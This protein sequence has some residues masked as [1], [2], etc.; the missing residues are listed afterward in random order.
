MTPYPNLPIVNQEPNQRMN[1]STFFRLANQPPPHL[2]FTAHRFTALT[3]PTL[4]PIVGKVQSLRF[5]R[6]LLAPAIDLYLLDSAEAAAVTTGLL[7]WQ[8]RRLRFLPARFHT[9]PARSLDTAVATY[10]A[11]QIP[12]LKRLIQGLDSPE[13]QLIL[14]DLLREGQKTQTAE[15]VFYLFGYQPPNLLFSI[16]HV[17]DTTTSLGRRAKLSPPN[18]E[19]VDP[20]TV[21]TAVVADPVAGGVN[22]FTSLAFLRQTF[23]QLSRVIIIAPHLT[24]YGALALS[25]FLDGEGLAATF[26]GFGAL[27][28]SNPPDMYFSPTPVNDPER[29]VDLRHKELMQLLYG[30]AAARLCVAGNWTAMFLAPRVG[31]EWFERELKENHLSIAQIK[32]RC[33]SLSQLKQL[34]FSLPEL[35]PASTYL[36]AV[37]ANQLSLLQRALTSA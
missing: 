22:Q 1:L 20:Q 36:N 9:G 10:Q 6:T 11:F 7:A 12:A 19:G 28:D 15:A 33:P 18:L 31:L 35:T 25:R 5:T 3:H 29:F 37:N 16:H 4:R 27:L 32:K 14:V 30:P 13:T 34:G 26:V 21:T 17:P 24:R 2:T 23:P 8:K